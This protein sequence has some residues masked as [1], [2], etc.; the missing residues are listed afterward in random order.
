MIFRVKIH[1]LKVYNL[2]GLGTF[3]QT[4]GNVYYITDYSCNNSRVLREK[5]NFSFVN[6]SFYPLKKS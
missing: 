2:I 5:R 3:P 4:R 1:V 6:C